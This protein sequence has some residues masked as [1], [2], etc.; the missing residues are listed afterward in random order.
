MPED[1]FDYLKL[2]L[3][4]SI[5]SSSDSKIW[6][7]ATDVLAR[8][9]AKGA[10]LEH[11]NVLKTIALIDMFNGASGLVSNEELLQAL[12]PKA[13]IKAIIKDLTSWSVI[14]LKKHLN[15]YSIYE[16]SDFDIE[17]A[18]AEAYA[19]IPTL[20]IQKLV[21]IANFKPI[22]AKR[23]YH[24]YGCM[25]WLDI[26]LKR[27]AKALGVDKSIP[28]SASWILEKLHLHLFLKKHHWIKRIKCIKYFF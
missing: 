19:A 5:L 16:G 14:I 21:D 1:L 13:N 17:K 8:C 22:I 15:A 26:L 10:S 4:S 24:K 20:E 27:E 28:G 6:N 9:Q 23:H 2:N 12:Y 7:I 11:I 25:R 18:L 3:E